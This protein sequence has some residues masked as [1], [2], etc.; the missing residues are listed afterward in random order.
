MEPIPK[1]QICYQRTQPAS[2]ILEKSFFSPVPFCWKVD[3]VSRIDHSACFPDKHLPGA[4]F[5]SATSL[6]I[7]VKVLRPGLLELQSNAFAHETVA[8]DSID[9]G[10]DVSLEEATYSFTNHG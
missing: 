7:G 6:G 8:V 5:L 1:R 3:N 2:D 10:F 9:E 4:N